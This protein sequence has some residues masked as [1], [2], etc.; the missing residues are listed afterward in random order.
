MSSRICRRYAP[1]VPRYLSGTLSSAWVERFEA[2]LRRCALCQAD[3]EAQRAVQHAVG[4]L[5]SVSEPPELTGQILGRIARFE[6]E[7]VASQR[8]PV[9]AGMS[10]LRLLS[11]QWALCWRWAA[12]AVLL[13][14]LYSL[15]QPAAWA[16][17]MAG[18]QRDADALLLL[19][20][21]PGPDEI[22]WGVWLLGAGVLLFV[23]MRVWRT[24]ASEAWRREL[25]ER[26]PQ[27]W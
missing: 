4:Q 16:Q 17:L 1:Q 10:A 13:L 11:E 8:L 27:L 25:S 12:G 5:P 19:L 15:A 6:A 24:D 21:M 9:P 18:L 2:H 20:T 22:S 14:A 7:R 26:L 23:A 3:L